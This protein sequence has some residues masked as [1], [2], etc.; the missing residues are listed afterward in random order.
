MCQRQQIYFKKDKNLT[1]LF[2]QKTQRALKS[3]SES[4]Y[5]YFFPALKFFIELN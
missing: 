1:D 4:V 5:I 3:P 2:L